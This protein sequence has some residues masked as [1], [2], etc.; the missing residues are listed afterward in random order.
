MAKAKLT[1]DKVKRHALPASGAVE[2]VDTEA[3][4]LICR[5]TRG[6]A[7]TMAVKGRIK[8]GPTFRMSLGAYTLR[9]LDGNDGWRSKARAIMAQARDGLDPRIRKPDEPTLP[10]APARNPS[11]D[12]G[13]TVRMTS[14]DSDIRGRVE[15][16][17]PAIV[18]AAP[19][20]DA[21]GE[22][23]GDLLDALFE[24][25]LFRLLLPRT[26]DGAEMHPGALFELMETIAAAD[27]SV[28]WCLAQAAGCSMAAAYL[29]PA[30]AD[31]VFDDPRAVLA[32]GPGRGEAVITD[33]GYRV[34][35]V[36]NFA[37][38]GRHASWFGG[39][40]RIIGDDGE[41]KSQPDGAPRERTLLFPRADVTLTDT[42]DVIGLRGT[43][44][45]RYAVTDLFVPDAF[46][47]AP[48]YTLVPQA[49]TP[50]FADGTLYRL[51]AQSVYGCA[52]AGIAL[53]IARGAMDAFETL[54]RDKA[55][56]GGAPTLREDAVAQFEYGKAETRLRAAR[57]FVLESADTLWNDVA[58]GGA[59]TRNHRIAVRMAVTH[60]IH[61]A[62]D[63]VGAVYHAAGTTSVFASQPFER[64]LRDANTVTQQLQGRLAF[65]QL[66]GQHLLGL[67]PDIR[68]V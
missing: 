64:R 5:I 17:I 27:G 34:T 48:D 68:L 19:R 61:E 59:Y 35:G 9:P 38:G 15:T 49:D 41:P 29:A 1:A 43:G 26:L 16:L 63:A 25:G 10:E 39:R 54:A 62:K 22:L 51:P 18:A 40:C 33:G 11:R 36:W 23:P 30:A 3:P 8:G 66:I 55:P 52:F 14:P 7:K 53:G 13:K 44:S 31:H 57:A 65:F 12:A 45:D 46:G 4:G 28:A 37:S 24:A 42:W 21:D 67:D 60:A 32:W 2:L 56:R 47:F 50:R 6:G 58:A 20:I